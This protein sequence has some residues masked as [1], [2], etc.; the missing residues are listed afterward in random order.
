LRA[1][2][3]VLERMDREKPLGSQPCETV[4]TVTVMRAPNFQ[5]EFAGKPR[6]KWMTASAYYGP[7][8]FWRCLDFLHIVRRPRCVSAAFPEHGAQRSPD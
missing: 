5:H 3:L 8:P 7:V 6:T 4:D 1:A 2:R